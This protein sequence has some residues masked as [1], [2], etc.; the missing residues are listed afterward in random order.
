LRLQDYIRARLQV[1]DAVR[2]EWE[3]GLFADQ[4]AFE[5]RVQ[6]V[7]MLFGGYQAINWL[8]AQG[9]IRWVVPRAGNEAAEG[10]LVFDNPN[11]AAAAK[12]AFA[13]GEPQ[14]TPPLALFQGVEGFASYFPIRQADQVVGQIN[15]VFKIGPLVERCLGSGTLDTHR[16]EI[17]DGGLLA[18]RSPGYQEA[19]QERPVARASA[20]VLDRTWQVRVV[21]GDALWETLDRDPSNVMFGLGLLLAVGIGL[22]LRLVMVRQEQREQGA[23]ERADLERQLHQAQKMEAVGRLAGGVAHDFN[24]MMMAV[25]GH[26]EL[27]REDGAL[28]EESRECVDEIVRAAERAA[29]LASQLLAFSQQQ[30]T[31]A[32]LLDLNAQLG[33]LEAM[34]RRVVRENVA[35]RLVLGPEL[36]PVVLDASQLGQVVMNLVVNAVDAMPRGGGLEIATRNAPAQRPPGAADGV[37]GPGGPREPGGQGGQGGPEDWVVLS[38][39]DEGT[40]MSPAIRDRIFEPF[41]TTKPVGQGT[42]LGLATSFAIV[43]RAGGVLTVDTAPD[44][45]T[46]FEVWLPRA[47]G[48]V[49]PAATVVTARRDRE[50]GGAE[51]VLLVED[52][53]QVREVVARSLSKAGY[54]V[55]AAVD[56]Q[57]ALARLDAERRDP[58]AV[59]SDV[60]MPGMDGMELAAALRDRGLEVP[61]LLCS[62]YAEEAAGAPPGDGLERLGVLFVAKPIAPARLLERLRSAL[63]GERP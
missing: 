60:V 31:D 1:V 50:A 23:R 3:R 30:V 46:T 38:V 10:R 47:H 7:A 35:L 26:A 14:V 17:V 8:D 2:R 53:A 36:W 62:G 52:E 22:L 16:L 41:F 59:I 40:G 28:D 32:V 12:R 4:A 5:S 24:N 29:T 9:R 37:I 42:G 11:A 39:S 55:W 25:L 61:I 43:A 54:T 13:T 44:M 34:L 27:V 33:D 21:P 19:A 51:T 48:V 58:D 56:G 18:Y 57:T 15:G 6:V 20:V 49:A 45:G 63:D